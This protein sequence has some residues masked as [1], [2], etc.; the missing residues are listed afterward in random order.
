MRL[1]RAMSWLALCGLGFT[2][3][4]AVRAPLTGETRP[5]QIGHGHLLAISSGGSTIPAVLEFTPTYAEH[6]K[7]ILDANCVSCH[8][9][10][11]IAPFALDTLDAARDSAK[12]IAAA[13]RG[14]VMPPFPPAGESPKFLHE[15]RLSDDEIAVLSNWYWS[16]APAG[17]ASKTRAATPRALPQVRADLNLDIGREF[18]PSND[19][20]DEYRCF[21]LEPK[22]TGE[23]FITG[24][25]IVP[26]NRKVV[27]HVLVYELPES[28]LAEAR[29]LERGEADGRGGYTCFGGP[30]VGS[31][32]QPIGAWAP[33]GAGVLF[34]EGTG[35]KLRAGS[36]LVAQVH[37]NLA[38]GAE[39]DRT[40]IKLSL[41]PEGA[42]LRAL[43]N[44]SPVAPV[45]IA[46][47][48]AT[49]TDAKHPC[50]RAAAYERVLQLNNSRGNQRR[51]AGRDLEMCAR[52]LD[53]YRDPVDVTR[54]A[55]SC[56]YFS[57]ARLTIY[58]LTGHMHYLGK[59]VKIELLRP[60][61]SRRVLLDIPRWDFHWQGFYWLQQ[62]ASLQRGDKVRIS[63]VFDNS[64][65]NQPFLGGERREPRYIV[66]GEGTGEEMC[67]SYI[68]ATVDG[69]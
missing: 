18:K 28:L 55:T 22:L 57:P 50:S 52:T 59:S 8:T 4:L 39:P 17:D 37:Y 62:P 33:G 60:D 5:E 46:C 29:G 14:R 30:R 40:A 9:N 48:G 54:I 2:A 3:V 1:T 61:G 34:P 27:H 10:G 20:S 68:Q 12:G 67:L 25:D 38:N 49:P 24:Y 56:E 51:M 43:Q 36:K 21:I 11:G 44:F 13:T 19:L 64:K 6:V 66:W 69:I 41:A 45:E 23:R 42:K 65:A 15:T 47:A 58:G 26:G 35:A 31:G 16:G 53:T 32:L 7:P 63:C